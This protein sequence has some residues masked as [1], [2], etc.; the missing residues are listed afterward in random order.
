MG[1]P[2]AGLRSARERCHNYLLAQGVIML[3]INVTAE[4]SSWLLSTELLEPKTRHE[5]AACVAQAIAQLMDP[6]W[7][8]VVEQER[9]SAGS[10]SFRA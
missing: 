8:E 9:A 6:E 10:L 5:D 2:D 4:N 1:N 3:T 7:R